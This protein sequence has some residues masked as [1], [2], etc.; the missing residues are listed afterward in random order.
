M[1]ILQPI[2]TS[3]NIVIIPR[4]HP[5]SV[6][7]TLTD[8][9]TGTSATPVVTVANADGFMTLSGTF[10][11]T[12]KRFYTIEVKDGSTLIYRGRVFVT[13]QTDYDKYTTSDYVEHTSNNDFVIL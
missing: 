3:Q 7:L 13:S 11:L 12:D 9:S 8:D 10:S 2:G 6:T 4:S 1:H 5:S